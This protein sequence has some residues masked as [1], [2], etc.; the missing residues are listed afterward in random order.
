MGQAGQ[1]LQ[2]GGVA[3]QLLAGGQGPA[4]RLL[5]LDLRQSRSG[6]QKALA[7]GGQ[8]MKRDSNRYRYG[9]RKNAMTGREIAKE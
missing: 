3:V 4:T 7:G 6:G 9:I 8:G 2:A 1:Q 5:R